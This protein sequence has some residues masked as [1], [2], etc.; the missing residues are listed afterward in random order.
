MGRAEPAEEE[1]GVTTYFVSGHL[2]L[3]MDAFRE[4]YAPLI[5]ATIAEDPD[6]SFVVG[7]ARGCD[8]MAQLYLRDAHAL[9]VQVFHMLAKPRNN[10]GGFPTIGGFGSDGTRDAAMTEASDADIAW[11]RPGRQGSGTAA[12][13][14][15]RY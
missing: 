4:H 11:V 10:V 6:A 5:A 14:A 2:D 7:D 1:A 15:R 9:R 3:T 8:L 13:L 12:N